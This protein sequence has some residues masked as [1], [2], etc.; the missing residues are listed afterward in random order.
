MAQPP[1]QV[2]RDANRENARGMLQRS[3]HARFLL[4]FP[5]VPW[6][7]ACGSAQGGQLEATTLGDLSAGSA[8]RGS[9]LDS[10]TSSCGEGGQNAGAISRSPYVQ[11]TTAHATDI[12]F[13]ADV[14]APMVDL[15]SADGEVVASVPARRDPGGSDEQWVASLEG[16]ESGTH[17]CYSLR[18][19]TEPAG[20]RTA[21]APGSG[22]P[23]R[24]VVF[25]DS[26]SASERQYAVLDQLY[27]VPF[28]LMLHTGDIAYDNGSARQLEEQ[29]FDVYS[30]L[31]ASIPAF[32]TSGNHDY[33][34]NGAAPFR[35]AFDLPDN[36]GPAGV[37]R[38]YSFDWGD[39]H[40]VAL[41]TERVGREQVAWLEQDLAESALP[42]TVVYLHRPPFSSGDHGSDQEVRRSFV[43]VFE[44]H[45]V[46]VVFAGHDH[47]YER[48]VPQNGVTYIITGGGG[49]G[50]RGVGTSSFT[51]YSQSV[52]HF[53]YA[54]LV[55]ERLR[56]FA[57]DGTGAE[58]DSVVLE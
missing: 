10:F 32:P 13:T 55:D 27:T 12:V 19:L 57:V 50:T 5:L 47:H 44:R 56:I 2:D 22:E 7:A 20:L 48:T 28:D 39:I 36:G 14:E 38:W 25:G 35:A 21:P 37:E 16:L 53:V 40:F 58:F 17:Y 4:A 9:P 34:T 11:R 8:P 3:Q 52:L 1:W 15:S 51:A 45:G 43:P 6:L 33:E 30:P 18:G 29:F 26:G 24:F 49:R 54:E 46:D 41:D 31:I 42:W 23:V